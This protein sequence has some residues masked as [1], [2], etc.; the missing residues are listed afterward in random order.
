[1]A[2]FTSFGDAFVQ[3]ENRLAA[4]KAAAID[5]VLRDTDFR[6]GGG[7]LGPGDVSFVPGASIGQQNQILSEFLQFTGGAVDAF[8]NPIGAIGSAARRGSAAANIPGVGAGTFGVEGP[9]GLSGPSRLLQQSGQISRPFLTGGGGGRAGAGPGETAQVTR[10]VQDIQPVLEGLLAQLVEE[11]GTPQA[12][13]NSATRAAAAAEL[14]QTVQALTPAQ[15]EARATAAVDLVVQRALEEALPQLQAAGEAAGTS[16]N[17]LQALAINDL[18]TRTA[19][20]TA[21]AILEAIGNFAAGQAQAGQTL[22]QITEI[23]P[24]SRELLALLTDVPTQRETVQASG[25][26]DL[27][28]ALGLTPENIISGSPGTSFLATS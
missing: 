14:L 16:T 17:A 6:A 4:A 21:A 28:S 7:T 8:G 12:Q 2:T 26:I 20:T 13:Q 25:S 11:G 1:M 23:D 19:G 5:R 27:L 18:A 22:Q 9:G 15:A 3:S 10:T 24:V